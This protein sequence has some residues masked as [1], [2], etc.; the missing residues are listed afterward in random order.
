MTST[1]ISLGRSLVTSDK[2][3]YYKPHSLAVGGVRNN[4]HKSKK[5]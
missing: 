2:A 1:S 5:T 3:M 4:G